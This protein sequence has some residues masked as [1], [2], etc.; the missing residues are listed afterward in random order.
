MHRQNIQNKRQ[1][2]VQLKGILFDMDG[3]FVDS[4]EYILE[5][6]KLMLAEHGVTAK[7]EVALTF[8]GMGENKYI[9]G[10]AKINGFEVDIERHKARTD[11]QGKTLCITWCNIFCQ[12]MYFKRTKDGSSQKCR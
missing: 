9:A 3:V 11:F 6:T 8:A 12:R 7:K 2:Q 4:E 5:A 1:K 10:I